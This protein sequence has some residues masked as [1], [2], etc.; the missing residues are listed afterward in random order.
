MAHR[1]QVVIDCHNP[2]RLVEFWALALDYQPEDPPAGFDSWNAYWRHLKV[3]E[4]ELDTDRDSCDSIVD[5]AGVGPR[6]WFQIVPE[7]KAIKNRVHLDVAVSG[8][9]RDLPRALRKERVD[10]KAAELLDAGASVVMTHDVEGSEHYAVTMR[11]PEGN[12]F[13][14]N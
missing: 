11:D 7:T 6:I 1:I 3:P 13:C 2:A 4:E 10:A 12:E 8:G 9:P 14:L 5:P